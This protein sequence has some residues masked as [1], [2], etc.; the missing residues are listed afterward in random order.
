MTDTTTTTTETLEDVSTFALNGADVNRVQAT[1]WLTEQA[2]EI[3]EQASSQE[4]GI[5]TEQLAIGRKIHDVVNGPTV[6]ALVKTDNRKTARSAFLKLIGMPKNT[7]DKYVKAYE[8]SARLGAAVK[9]ESVSVLYELR[10]VADP[11]AAK[12]A[13][14][15]AAK[16]APG[17]AA[18]VTTVKGEVANL[19]K[20]KLTDSGKTARTTAEAN[21]TK[22][23][24]TAAKAGNPIDETVIETVLAGSVADTIKAG[25]FVKVSSADVDAAAAR[26]TLLAIAMR[27]AMT[28]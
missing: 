2:T 28:I 6:L 22:A 26:L 13:L 10:H 23:A 18:T 9:G 15:K 1:A 27:E 12:A 4:A 3:R 21:A 8:S 24:A 5:I 7:G 14:V 11:K 25:P 16:A 19:P 17:D 20:T